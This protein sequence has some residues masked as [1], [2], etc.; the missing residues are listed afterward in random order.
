MQPPDWLRPNKPIFSEFLRRI[1]L[2]FDIRSEQPAETKRKRKTWPDILLK[3]A[4]I[5]E[6]GGWCQHSYHDDDGRHCAMGA[7][8]LAS[9]HRQTDAHGIA[10]ARLHREVNQFELYSGEI[11]ITRWND[12]LPWDTGAQTVIETMRKVASQ[13]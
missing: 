11:D 5:I 9:N 10:T 4:E 6:E 8:N 1:F 2:P 7:M 13:K 3:A 12:L